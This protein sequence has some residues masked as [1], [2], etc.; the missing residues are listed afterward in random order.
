MQLIREGR[1]SQE[2]SE[3]MSHDLNDRAG[4]D[5][6]S[7]RQRTAQQRTALALIASVALALSTAVAATI[8]SIGMARA[9][10]LR[11]VADGDSG[12]FAVAL[13]LG[14]VLAGMGGLTAIVTRNERKPPT[15]PG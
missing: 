4:F 9:E 12:P 15:G 10:T 5:H 8:V 6:P 11:T 7:R 1:A 13:F 14:L 3:D 2:M